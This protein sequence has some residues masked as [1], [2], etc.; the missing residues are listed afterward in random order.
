M[1]VEK[2]DQKKSPVVTQANQNFYLAQPESGAGKGVLVLP[3]WWGLNQFF[4]ELCDRL[5]A[6]GF[7]ALAPDLYHGAT[8]STVDEAKKLRSKLKQDTVAQEITQAAEYLRTVC[9]AGPE[10]LGVIGFSLGGYWAL[11]LADQESGQVAATVVF[12]G[13][14]NGD[15]TKSQSAFQFHF[16]ETD[17]YVAA[18]GINKLQRSLKAA[19][20][21]AEFHTYAGTRH[22][23]FE[24]DRADAYHAPAAKLAWD[25]TLAF[26]NRHLK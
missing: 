3:A 14:R 19:G 12:Y 13:T 10:G 18:S 6:E 22:W 23:F 5:A 1:V 21:E 4:K 15:Y 25:R 16:A 8:A 7:V 2:M 9:G 20:K 17:D 26:L 24:Q 11:W